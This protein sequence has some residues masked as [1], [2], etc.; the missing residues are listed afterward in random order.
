MDQQNAL[1]LKLYFNSYDVFHI[2][3]TRVFIFNRLSED[4]TSGSKYVEDIEQIK[5]L[6]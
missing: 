5:I 4:D 2:F 3:Q 1:L 6:V